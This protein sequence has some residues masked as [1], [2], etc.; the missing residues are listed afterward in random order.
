LRLWNKLSKIELHFFL[1]IPQSAESKE[2]HHHYHRSTKNT[3]VSSPIGIDEHLKENE[4]TH[5]LAPPPVATAMNRSSEEDSNDSAFTDNGKSIII[6]FY[7]IPMLQLLYNY[8]NFSQCF[9]G[10]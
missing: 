7:D 9:L 5:L 2:K 1:S 6:F 10:N 4:S 8:F 3:T